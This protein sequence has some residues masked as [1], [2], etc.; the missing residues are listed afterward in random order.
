MRMALLGKYGQ[1]VPNMEGVDREQ[2]MLVP[3]PKGTGATDLPYEVIMDTS[4]PS[5]VDSSTK[6]D[7]SSFIG[8]LFHLSSISLFKGLSV[9]FLK[10]SI[11]IVCV[12]SLLC[13]CCAPVVRLLHFILALMFDLSCVLSIFFSLP[14]MNQWE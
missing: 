4:T 12:A 8:Y 7:T 9:F 6:H 1:D 5:E 3:H 13:A 2:G 11:A 14:K 10:G